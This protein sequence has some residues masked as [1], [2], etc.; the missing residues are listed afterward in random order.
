MIFLQWLYEQ[1]Y[2]KKILIG[3]NHD[4]WL[5]GNNDRQH[6]RRIS[7]YDKDDVEF[8]YLCDAGT[9][10][11]G[12]KIWATPWT[13][14][15][16]GMNP[17]CKAFTSDTEV[18]LNE[19]W[20]L[21]PDNVDILISHGPSWGLNDKN[22]HGENC[23]SKSLTHWIANHVDSLKIFLCGHIHEAYGTYDIRKPPVS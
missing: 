21:I 16:K 8:D 13:H 1:P 6:L 5:I 11:E 23:G 15:F 10:F 7:G 22:K 14:T 20:S 19:H 18:E 12:L 3:G 4:N 9:E 2:S 17:K